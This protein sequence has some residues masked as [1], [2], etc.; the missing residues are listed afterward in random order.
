MKLLL[1]HRMY[2]SPSACGGKLVEFESYMDKH[3]FNNG[4]TSLKY[5]YPLIEL[6]SGPTCATQTSNSTLWT[7]CKTIT[8]YPVTDGVTVA[9]KWVYGNVNFG[10]SS[11]NSDLSTAEI[12]GIAAG[13]AVFLVAAAAGAY[14]FMGAGGSGAASAAAGVG[15]TGV[16]PMVSA[17]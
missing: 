11:S 17:V 4:A 13:G 8:E 3:C 2:D 12:A 1:L 14:F 16:N 15:S 7:D 9:T 10:G 5:E 6:Y